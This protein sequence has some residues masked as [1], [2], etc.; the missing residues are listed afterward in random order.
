[1]FD[2]FTSTPDFTPYDSV[3]NNIPLDDMNSP[4]RKISDAALRKDAYVSACLSLSLP[5]QCPEDLLNQILWRSI[6]GTKSHIPP[7]PSK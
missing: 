3:S 5:D 6:K 7:G 4:A 2:C 1:M